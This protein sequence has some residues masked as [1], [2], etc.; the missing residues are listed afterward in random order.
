MKIIALFLL[1]T[2]CDIIIATVI[3]AT[4]IIFILIII[5]FAL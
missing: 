5:T 2:Q 4:I 3:T 1:R